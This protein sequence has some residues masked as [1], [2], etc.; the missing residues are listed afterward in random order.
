[1]IDSVRSTDGRKR[2]MIGA[3]EMWI[4]VVVASSLL[5]IIAWGAVWVI[6]SINELGKTVSAMDART[7]VIQAQGNTLTLQL[8]DVPRLTTKVAELSVQVDRNSDD[9]KELRGMRG[10]K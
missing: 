7:Q 10:L 3:I 9:I 1:M 8:A 4:C 5:A 2:Y 6:T